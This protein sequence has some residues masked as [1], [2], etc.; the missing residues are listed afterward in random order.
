MDIGRNVADAAL[1][2]DFS[3]L[4]RLRADATKEQGSEESKAASKEV[5]SQIEALFFQMVLKSMRDAQ[6]IGQDSSSDQTRFYQDMFDKQITLELS[7]NNKGNGTGLAAT[8]E[9]QISGVRHKVNSAEDNIEL[10]RTQI[11]SQQLNNSMITKPGNTGSE[12]E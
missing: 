9:Q 8:I 11:R 5:A 7:K 4:S 6:S 10:I 1:Y 3:E 12:Q 2:T